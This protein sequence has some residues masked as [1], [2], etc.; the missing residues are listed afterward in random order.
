MAMDMSK[1]RCRATKNSGG[2]C[3]NRVKPPHRYCLQHSNSTPA[4]KARANGYARINRK[5]ERQAMREGIANPKFDKRESE[6]NDIIYSRWPNDSE[7]Y[8]AR[9]PRGGA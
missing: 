7:Y 6:A 1:P 5:R 2:R 3:R 9:R 8:G 4:L